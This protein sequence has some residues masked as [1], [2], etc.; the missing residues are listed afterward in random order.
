MGVLRG[1]DIASA[2]IRPGDEALSYRLD[3]CRIAIAGRAID[4]EAPAVWP[5]RGGA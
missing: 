1:V 2:F 5:Q 3:L 4:C